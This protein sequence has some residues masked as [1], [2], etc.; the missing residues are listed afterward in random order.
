MTFGLENVLSAA[1]RAAVKTGTSKDMRDNWCVG[2]SRHYTVGVW[3]GNF[4]GEPMRE[5]SGVTGAAP[6][7]LEIDE[8]PARRGRRPGREPPAGLVRAEAGGPAQRGVVHPR[9]RA[10]RCRA[11]DAAV[12]VRITYPPAGAGVRARSRHTPRAAA[13]RFCRSGACDRA[14][15]DARRPRSWRRPGAR[16]PGRPNRGGTSSAVSAPDGA[17]IGCAF[18]FAGS[19]RTARSGPA[20]VDSPRP[21]WYDD[22][23]PRRGSGGVSGATY[24]RTV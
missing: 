6:L 8:L 14:A 20:R 16:S 4:S 18:R 15:L 17:A 1:L 10:G 12:G 7:W 21:L 3:V 22:R 5:V 13:D 19:G 23:L 2:Y 9:H 24:A 11:Y